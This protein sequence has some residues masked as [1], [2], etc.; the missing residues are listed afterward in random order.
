MIGIGCVVLVEI[1]LCILCFDVGFE[2]LWYVCG[3][4]GDCIVGI[5]WI[6]CCKWFIYYVDVFDFFWC[7]YELVWGVIVIVV[8]Y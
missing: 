2:L 1:L 6:F 3:D 8:V 4:F 7:Y 5:V